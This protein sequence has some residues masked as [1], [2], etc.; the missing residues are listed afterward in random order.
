MMRLGPLLAPAALLTLALFS[1]PARAQEGVDLACV[2]PAGMHLVDAE[3]LEIERTPVRL[4]FAP[5]GQER[6][7][8]LVDV[9]VE[10][11]HERAAE[12]ARWFRET[13]AGELRAAP[14]IGDAAAGDEGLVAF[15]RDSLFVVV[16]R[17]GGTRDVRALAR[18]IDAA[19][20]CRSSAPRPSVQVPD[21]RI[22]A[23]LPVEASGALALHVV[24]RGAVASRRTAAGWV[25]TRTA[26]GPAEVR[27]I[28]VDRA[29]RRSVHV[30]RLR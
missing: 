14:G 25:V 30:R 23:T 27:V 6:A 9:L 11:S 2:T 3:V 28:V 29:L 4:R 12:A 15:T 8:I 5:A 13:V 18:D 22:G 17:I 20:P 10:T 24:A 1:A 16:R 26:E 21:P 7:E 19:L